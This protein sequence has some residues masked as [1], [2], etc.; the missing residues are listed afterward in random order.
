VTSGAILAL[1]AAD[2][3]SY[4]G[5]GTAWTDLSGQKNDGALTNGPTYS[6]SNGGNIVFDGTNDCVIVRG[7]ALILSTVAYTKI[8]WFYTTNF[9][10]YNNLISGGNA[11]QHAF[12][13]AG[14]T[15]LNAGHN[16]SWST[17]VGTTVLSVNTWY[18]GAVTFNATT[19]WALYLNGTLQS[20]N[21]S[22][23]TFLTNGGGAAT[24]GEILLGSYTTGV[25]TLGGGISV[26]HVYNRALS[27]AEISQNFNASRA[28]F[29]I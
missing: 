5:S 20:I 23:T 24:A 28:R 16:G 6:N 25:S 9:S 11:T 3:N 15:Y 4:P 29:G 21:A 27:S 18:H 7:N 10:Y 17:V 2:R 22:T 14:S 26:A 13:L 19:G 1:D 12:W 8:V